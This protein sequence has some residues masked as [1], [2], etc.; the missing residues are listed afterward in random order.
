ML[1]E[2]KVY[3]AI[4]KMA[5][6]VEQA[7]GAMVQLNANF[8]AVEQA[9]RAFGEHEV[10]DVS[11]MRTEIVINEYAQTPSVNVNI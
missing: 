7:A 6:G 4:L 11:A 1:E 3:S 5:D 8:R 2:L 9:L 10:L